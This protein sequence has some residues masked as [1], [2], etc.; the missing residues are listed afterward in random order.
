MARFQMVAKQANVT[1]ALAA[2]TLTTTPT[3]TTTTTTPTTLPRNPQNRETVARPQGGGVTNERN[4]V[5][6]AVNRRN[7][8]GR[9]PYIGLW[10]P[11]EFSIAGPSRQSEPAW[12][13]TAPTVGRSAD[14]GS[15]A[16][17]CG[18]DNAEADGEGE[19]KG[20]G[21]GE[22]EGNGKKWDGKG[23]G[24]GKASKWD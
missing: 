3:T 13:T 12:G 17:R 15:V 6:S 20:E 8:M 11:P 1:A 24:K 16:G 2:L 4:A 7:A 23:K 5:E 10:M 9:R 14:F 22:G 21:A 19:G 18:G